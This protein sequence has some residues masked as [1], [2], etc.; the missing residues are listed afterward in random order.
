MGREK[1]ELL[2]LVSRENLDLCYSGHSISFHIFLSNLLLGKESENLET[3]P[4]K[5]WRFKKINRIFTKKKRKIT[6]IIIRIF[7]EKLL[8]Y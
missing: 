1:R 6:I 7:Q 5:L 4:E 8:Y 3:R 2:F